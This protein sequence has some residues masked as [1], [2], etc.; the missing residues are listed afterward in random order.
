M[1]GTSA[2]W[3]SRLWARRGLEGQC[4]CLRES[5]VSEMHGGQPLRVVVILPGAVCRRGWLDMAMAVWNAESWAAAVA[6]Q[7]QRLSRSIHCK[8]NLYPRFKAILK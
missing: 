2:R 7:N 1:K 4:A 8:I 6:G 3:R 5:G